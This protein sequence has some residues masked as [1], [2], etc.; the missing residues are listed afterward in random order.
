MGQLYRPC[1]PY[2]G[3][4]QQDIR[5][6]KTLVRVYVIWFEVEDFSPILIHFRNTSGSVTAGSIRDLS[7]EARPLGRGLRA[8]EVVSAQMY[9]KRLH[10]VDSEK[11]VPIPEFRLAPIA[12]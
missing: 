5:L 7:C 10:M 9:S 8:C 11:S 6:D 4:E 2:E 1:N 3:P 12:P